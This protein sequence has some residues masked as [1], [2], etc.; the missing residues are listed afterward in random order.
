MSRGVTATVCAL[1]CA[2]VAAAAPAYARAE[3]F[4]RV[5]GLGYAQGAP[6]RAYL[7]SSAP[8]TGGTFAVVNGSGET[9]YSAAV[10]PSAGSWSTAYPYLYPLGFDGVR[11]P[12]VYRVTAAGASSPTFEVQAPSLLYAAPLA[13][14][15]S[16]FQNE[17]DGPEYVPSALRTAP[18]HVGDAHASVYAT[19]AVN[20]QGQFSGELKSLGATVDA[21]GGWWDAGD[22]LKFVETESY[23]V[24]MMLA[25]ARD[26]PAQMGAQAPAAQSFTGEARFGVQWLLR[27]FDDS[28]GT[29]YYQVGIG[30]G[31]ARTVGDHDIWRLP[32][33]DETYGGQDPR[34]RFIRRRPVF[35]AGA[36]G[37]P[38][39][40]NLAG[41]LAAAFALC[42]QDFRASEPAL[43]NR[44][45][46]AGEHVFALA[47]VHF[48]GRLLT[49]LPYGFY[50]ER[51]WRD[52]LELGAA[53]LALA[54]QG[55]GTLPAGLAHTEASYY[56]SSAARWAREYIGH[57]GRNPETLNLYDVSGLA[58]FELARAIRRAGSAAG[59]A[60][61]EAELTRSLRSELE[62]ASAQA[63]RDPFGFGVS[64]AQADTASFGDG[65]AVMA[66][67]YD[68][69]TGAGTYA[70]QQA[71]WLGNVLGANPWGVSMIIGDG[72]VFTDCPQH[73]V[74]NLMG[75]LDGIGP[76]LAGAVVEGPSNEHSAGEVEGMRPCGE[77]PGREY[78][79]FDG[80]GSIYQDSVASY[81][82]TEPAIDLTASSMLAFAWASGAAPAP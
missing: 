31:N 67:E 33:A 82:T 66:A 39:S 14:S 51:E 54:L 15:L 2:A 52:D 77:G 13:N 5:D 10:G 60:V 59:L 79:Q 30:A 29:L 12:G 34:D 20:A 57:G 64:W 1:A 43:A 61:D 81:T 9:V 76:V 63:A 75:S 44:C 72:S 26:F 45:L 70:A 11:A 16:F 4:V 58:H 19:P 3:A 25:G 28:T 46:L 21:S 41:R 17:R 35:R 53:E 42:F 40:P 37:S 23:T 71:D 24:A 38:I 65:L 74:A 18:A 48:K 73:Q 49:V 36:P 50:P 6:K 32:Q 68:W 22:Y 62:G 8:A 56:L 27:M 80:K 47:N 7:M 55:G 69:L 78:A